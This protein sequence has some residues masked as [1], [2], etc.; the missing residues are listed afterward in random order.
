MRLTLRTLLAYLD[1]V[2]EPSQ[3]KLMGQK[4][5]ESPVAGVLVSRIREVMRRR[6]LLSPD[7]SGSHVGIDPNIVAQY[8]DNTLPPEQVADVERVLLSSDELLAEV[9]ACHQVLT[10]VLGEPCEVSESSRERLYALGPVAPSDQLHVEDAAPT[11]ASVN[12][13][14]PATT[15]VQAAEASAQVTVLRVETPTE[16][17]EYLRPHPWSQRVVPT[18]IIAL[19]VLVCV[20]LLISD[21]SFLT[22][23]SKAKHELAKSSRDSNSENGS[24]NAADLANEPATQP[25]TDAVATAKANPNSAPITRL[26]PAPPP[27]EPDTPVAVTPK[28]SK[29]ASATDTTPKAGSPADA[30]AAAK[31]KPTIPAAPEPGLPVPSEPKPVVATPVVPV[32]YTSTEGVVLRFDAAK[33]HWFLV[34]R[35]SELKVGELLASLEPYEANL[36]FDQGSLRATIIGDSM[37][38]VIGAT[39]MAPTGLDLRRGRVILQGSRKEAQQPAALAIVVGQ[40]IWKLELL[41]SETVCAIEI[42]PREPSRFEK[43]HDANWYVGTLYVLAGSA[44]WTSALGKSLEV[45]DRTGFPIAPER[46]VAAAKTVPISFPSPPDWSDTQKRKLAPLRRY[47]GLFE[48]KFGLDDQADQTLQALITDDNANI[49]GLAARGLTLTDSYAATVQALSLC[50]NEE[51]R[52]AARDGLHLWLPMAAEHGPLLQ[53]EL[54]TNFP[55]ADAEAVYRLLW[56]FT[57]EDGRDKVSS[58]QLV[59]WLRSQNQTVRELAYHWIAELTKPRKWDYRATESNP[60]RRESAVRRIETLIEKDGALI[61]NE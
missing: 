30:L 55:P 48:K 12:E 15:S 37:V 50:K 34:P 38:R 42:M 39:D 54:E 3:T 28:S 8:L 4:I 13:A 11:L 32:E 7:V 26:D 27:D 29:P 52:F 9:A 44:K 47:A 31:A 6:R 43:L 23:V 22:G 46:G 56:G 40:D 58:L 19:L 17:P 1:D 24:M 36:S 57:R 14:A 51:G 10:L 41:S 35:Q 33:G 49:S 18:A 5:Q 60:G 25:E 21:P 59:G 20:G 53:K 45:A 2:L 16:L 61:K